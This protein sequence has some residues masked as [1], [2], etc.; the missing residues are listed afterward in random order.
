MALEEN[1]NKQVYFCCDNAQITQRQLV[2]ELGTRFG[3]EV[4]SDYSFESLFDP[5]HCV[6]TLDLLF[7]RS[8]SFEFVLKS[9]KN[10]QMTSI[11]SL[12]SCMKEVVQVSSSHLER[13][14]SGEVGEEDEDEDNLIKM[15][16]VDFQ[17]I[18]Q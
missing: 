7:Q 1:G 2:E 10:Q 18:V 13:G 15:E 3:K 14:E 6:L 8:I 17:D 9:K 12:D 16:G 4:S 5:S 11:E